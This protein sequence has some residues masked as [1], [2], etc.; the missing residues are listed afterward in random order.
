MLGFFWSF[1]EP[2]LLLVILYLVF[3]NIFKYNIESYPLF[4]LGNLI[5]W[6]FV[7]RSTNFGM[8]SM[9]LKSGILTKIYF[10]RE[11]VV[12]SS[13]LTTFLMLG[14][15]IIVYGIF[16]M[17]FQFVPTLSILF[18]PIPIIFLFM[19]VL[20]LSFLLSVTNVFFRDI[21]SIWAIVLQAGFF[22]TP[23]I[24]KMEVLPESLQ[25]VLYFSPLVQIFEM[26]HNAVLYNK[27]PN[28]FELIYTALVSSAMLIIGYVVFNRIQARSIEEL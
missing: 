21:Q 14:L 12:L 4:L 26:F 25:N 8:Q 10:P 28:E 22:L 3:T 11:I 16:M 19:L 1:L 15:E 6:N 24:Y 13:V 5:L 20:G 18:I 2:L 23:I 9:L 17:I 7:S 27:L